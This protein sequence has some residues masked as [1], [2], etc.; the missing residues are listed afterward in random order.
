MSKKAKRATLQQNSR[1]LAVTE[2]EQVATFV[3]LGVLSPDSARQRLRDIDEQSGNILASS[4]PS[5]PAR[6]ENDSPFV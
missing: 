5:S 3:Q 2:R 1:E 6:G 4:P